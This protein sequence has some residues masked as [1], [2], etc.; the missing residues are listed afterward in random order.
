M[1]FDDTYLSRHTVPALTTIHF[2]KYEMGYE[3]MNSLLSIIEN[4]PCENRKLETRLIVRQS[5]RKQ[6]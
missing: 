3:L 6:M 2:P 1:G 4:R 5:T